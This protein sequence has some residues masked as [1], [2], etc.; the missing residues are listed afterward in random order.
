MV[1]EANQGR[2]RYQGSVCNY[3]PSYMKV[4]VTLEMLSN[5]KPTKHQNSVSYLIR[6]IARC[7]VGN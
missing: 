7:L 2:E 1:N 6:F 3:R 4:T 5:F